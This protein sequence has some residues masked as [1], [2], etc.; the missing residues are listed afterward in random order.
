MVFAGHETTA[1]ALTYTWYLLARNPD[2]AARVYEE[3]DAVVGEDRPTADH[4]DDFSTTGRVVREAMRLYPP[5]HTVPRRTE[6][7]IEIGGYRLPAGA[8]VH[9]PVLLIQRDARFFDDP[10]A[11]RPDRWTGDDDRPA[12][13]Y[14]PFGGGPRRCIGQQFALTEATLAVASIARKYR[15]DWAGTGDLGLAP[16]MTTQPDGEVP[17]L[18]R[19]RER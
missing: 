1:L 18:I 16:R 2:V 6:R 13:A 9:L 3:V 14:F 19:A 17:M 4:L 15:L 5:V 12:F 10:L 11:F 8:E 7:E